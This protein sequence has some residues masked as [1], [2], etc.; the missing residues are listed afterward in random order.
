MGKPTGFMDYKRQELALRAPEERM[1]GDQDEQPAAEGGT[2]LSGCTL[3][4][5]RCAL[6][7]QRPD[8]WR[9]GLR[10]SVA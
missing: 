9:Y 7:P 2:A 5:L 6:L 3:H 4:E 8:D 10:L 1:A